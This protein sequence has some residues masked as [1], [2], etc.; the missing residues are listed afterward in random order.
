MELHWQ[1]DWQRT[2]GQ[3]VEIRRG[4]ITIRAG[5]VEAVTADNN[6]LWI[7]ASGVEPRQMVERANGNEVY[8]PYT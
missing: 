6:V 4:R 3:H 7:A 5:T 8:A 1:P 2:L